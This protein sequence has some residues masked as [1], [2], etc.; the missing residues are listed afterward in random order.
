MC[1]AP[2]WKCNDP[3][4]YLYLMDGEGGKYGVCRKC[5]LKFVK[6]R[7]PWPVI[8]PLRKKAYNGLVL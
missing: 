1:E 7:V 4:P 2:F 6:S 3:K 5:W 8:L